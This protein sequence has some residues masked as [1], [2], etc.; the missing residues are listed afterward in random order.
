MLSGGE[1]Q[2]LTHVPHADGRPRAGHDRRA[3][4]GPVAADRRSAWPSCLRE[5]ARRGISILLVEQKL[6]IALDIAQPR[7]TSWATA[8]S[9]SRARPPSSSAPRGRAQGVAGGLITPGPGRRAERHASGRPPARGAFA[10]PASRAG[11]KLRTA[12]HAPRAVPDPDARRS[13]RRPPQAGSNTR[14]PP[15]VAT[16]PS[17]PTGSAVPPV[18]N[19]TSAASSGGTCASVR[20]PSGVRAITAP[21]RTAPCRS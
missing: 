8:R 4:R 2:M 6:T 11:G 18:R 15:R 17:V 3:D 14:S 19:A 21:P 5:I 1:Q 16:R 20:A 9:C 13:A 12:R 10:T 7:S